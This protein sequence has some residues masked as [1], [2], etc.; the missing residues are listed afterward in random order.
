MGLSKN[1]TVI[2]LLITLIAI[3]SA[4][5]AL[6]PEGTLISRLSLL[7]LFALSGYYFIKVLIMKRNKGLFYCMFT[8]LLIINVVSY[9]FT[10]SHSSPLH[11][12]NFA[13]ILMA[14][15]PFYPFYYLSHKGYLKDKH[16]ILLLILIIP[17][18]IANFFYNRELVLAERIGAVDITNNAAYT[19]AF[20]IPYVYTIKG[21]KIYSFI[22]LLI[23]LSFI[24]LGA[25]RGAI[26]TGAGGLFFY[27]YYQ[28]KTID[29][30]KRLRGYLLTL[31]I[32]VILG[33]FAH[34]FYMQNEYLMERMEDMVEG[35]S[36]GRDTIYS[37]LFNAWYK[38]NDAKTFYLGRG[39]AKTLEHSG[40][41]HFAHNDWLELLTNFGLFGV[42][43]YLTLFLSPIRYA[44][45]KNND[46][47]KRMMMFSILAI[48][49]GTTL[50]SM[51]YT[52]SNAM[53]QNIMLAHLLA[54]DKILFF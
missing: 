40:T 52:S 42:L 8:F 21:R 10:A 50:F 4:K 49:F 30:G 53:F 11:F 32:I 45:N 46:F 20:L 17:V 43:I 9:I 54:R 37:N 31:I 24:I 28:L 7:S 18:A 22:A 35:N 38:S 41:G 44:F 48:W 14:L 25:K 27:I 26:V 5:G 15:L 2:Y 12:N 13:G 47:D 51:N 29:K 1:N 23:L 16:L 39:F 36:S 34:D 19:F 3:Y 33:Y 6:Y